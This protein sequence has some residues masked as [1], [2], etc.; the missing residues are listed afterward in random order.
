MRIKQK[1]FSSAIAPN[2]GDAHLKHS[3]DKNVARF[4][5]V[6]FEQRQKAQTTCLLLNWKAHVEKE[7]VNCELD[8]AVWAR[9]QSDDEMNLVFVKHQMKNSFLCDYSVTN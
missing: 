2:S 9:C 7:I 5:N 6:A 3:H 8:F 4:L 1:I